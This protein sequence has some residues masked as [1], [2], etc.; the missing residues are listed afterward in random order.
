MSAVSVPRSLRQAGGPL[1]VDDLL[2][3]LQRRAAVEQFAGARIAAC[4]RATAD[5]IPAD[6]P[7]AAATS[8]AG[9][10]ARPDRSV[11]TAI[12][13]CGLEHRTDAVADR[14]AA[15][16]RDD[17]DGDAEMV[18][19]E[20]EQLAQPHRVRRRWPAWPIGPTGRSISRW[21]EPAA[22]FFDMIEATICSRVSRLSGRSTEIRMSSAGDRLT[23]PP[24]TRQPWQACDDLLHLV[25]AEI[26]ARQ[27]LHRVGGA[28]RRGDRARGG[29][30]DR[31]PVRGDD[32]HHDHRGTVAGDAADAML[33]DDDRL[34]PISIAFRPRPSPE[35]ARAVRRW[36]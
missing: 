7:R 22:S 11:S 16:G 32:R 5:R 20:L 33:V 2:H 17:L 28:G 30:R 6:A 18:A 19:D 1:R 34:G 23:C 36:S 27:H 15:V 10:A 9:P 8:R 26:D 24:Q 3:L 13:S 25:D 21:V 31:Q 35:P 4:R 29:L 12:T 14:L